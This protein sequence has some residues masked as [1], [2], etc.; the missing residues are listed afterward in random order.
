MRAFLWWI[1][2]PTTLI[3]VLSCYI[4]LLSFGSGIPIWGLEYYV[5]LLRQF[6]FFSPYFLTLSTVLNLA[7]RRDVG[8]EGWGGPLNLAAERGRGVS[9]SWSGGGGYKIFCRAGS[10]E[11]TERVG[12]GK[13]RD[14]PSAGSL[15]TTERVG[16]DKGR[17]QFVA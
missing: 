5:P 10:L 9:S 11:T 12:G 6:W 2:S 3:K 17:D 16:G 15:E 13:G 7:E 1:L 14:L 8:P 4:P